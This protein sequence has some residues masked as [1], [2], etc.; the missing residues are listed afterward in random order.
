MNTAKNTQQPTFIPCNDYKFN[1]HINMSRALSGV[2]SCPNAAVQVHAH[3][4]QHAYQANM[5]CPAHTK[6]ADMMSSEACV[7]CY[8]MSDTERALLIAHEP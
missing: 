6:G 2:Y 7:L 8:A 3:A 5:C 4:V 1:Y